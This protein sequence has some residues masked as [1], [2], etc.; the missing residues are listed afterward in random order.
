MN[1]E[2]FREYCLSLPQVDENAP[3][4]EPQYQSLVTFTVGGKWFALLDV[5]KKFCDLKASPEVIAEMQER[6]EAAFPAWHMNKSHWLGVRLGADMPDDVI[7][8]LLKAAYD[9]IVKSLPKSKRTDL[10]L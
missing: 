1:V 5:D 7:K 2:D 10:G 6:Y 3:W 8:S 9:L 4:T